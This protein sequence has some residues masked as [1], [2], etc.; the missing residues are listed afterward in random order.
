MSVVRS[1]A[2][3]LSYTRLRHRHRVATDTDTESGRDAAHTSAG[4]STSGVRAA[5]Q[6]AM[7][8]FSKDWTKQPASHR[9]FARGNAAQEALR[10]QLDAAQRI[11]MRAY[12]GP[13]RG[14]AAAAAGAMRVFATGT[15]T[16][17]LAG[18]LRAANR[19]VSAMARQNGPRCWQTSAHAHGKTLLYDLR[20]FAVWSFAKL[21]ERKL[22]RSSR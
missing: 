6:G 9:V 2:K 22:K 21:T 4:Q 14:T 18:Q 15:A 7:S 3:Q 20:D 16:R 13:T 1:L 11:N 17:N 12:L 19:C 5:A 8:V 10:K